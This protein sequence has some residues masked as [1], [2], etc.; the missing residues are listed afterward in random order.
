VNIQEVTRDLIRATE[1]FYTAVSNELTGKKTPAEA[2]EIARQSIHKM[3]DLGAED[4]LKQR[5]ALEDLM[6][7]FG[8]RTKEEL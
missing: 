4:A 8:M 6:Q 5:Q 7:A 2:I 1:R 3:A